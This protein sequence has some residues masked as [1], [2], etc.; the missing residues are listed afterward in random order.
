M[1]TLKLSVPNVLKCAKGLKV[2]EPT[3]AAL[4]LANSLMISEIVIKNEAQII[5]LEPH[6]L[7]STKNYS[8]FNIDEVNRN[9]I[10]VKRVKYF[11]EQFQNGT[12]VYVLG[13]SYV[14]RVYDENGKVKL[15]FRDGVHKAIAQMLLGLPIVYMI[16]TQEVSAD[17]M[18]H[19][20]SSVNPKWSANDHFSSAFKGGYPLAIEFNKI[21]SET[22]LKH[23]IPLGKIKPTELYGL[24]K[25]DVK[26][27]GA[28]MH[29]PKRNNYNSQTL[30][31]QTKSEQFKDLLDSFIRIKVRFAKERDCYKI[32]K[33]V[34][35]LHFNKTMSF[36][37][38][39]F[40]RNVEQQE[41]RHENNMLTIR[42]EIFRVSN[43]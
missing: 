17:M 29:S 22:V 13:T 6:K 5:G 26:Y 39:R 40:V 19:F 2:V 30:A 14:N 37:L 24:I 36:N 41:F 7:Y 43:I 16:L 31:E 35:N 18:A 12:F 33:E 21:I 25:Q 28:G 15:V 8:M 9:G 20:N 32:T 27:F 42:K 23:K 10:D 3:K 11:I 1:K 4:E 38:T 34:F